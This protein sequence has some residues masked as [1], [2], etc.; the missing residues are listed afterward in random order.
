MF[1]D[2]LLA[3]P[4]PSFAAFA[5]RRAAHLR[6]SL[7][8]EGSRISYALANEANEQYATEVDWIA[9]HFGSPSSIIF[10]CAQFTRYLQRLGDTVVQFLS[11]LRELARKCEFLPAQFGEWLPDQF[12]AGC[13]NDRIRERLLQEPGD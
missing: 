11:T 1:E 12:A 3:T 10:N 6:S 13:T 4:F 9:W 7:R 8:A 2:W 5:P